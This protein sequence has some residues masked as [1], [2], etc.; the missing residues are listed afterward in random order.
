MIYETND[1]F[2]E[3]K[4]KISKVKL[5]HCKCKLQLHV[6]TLAIQHFTLFSE[7]MYFSCSNKP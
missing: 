2:F 5:A 1:F 3:K 4:V 7:E 6:V